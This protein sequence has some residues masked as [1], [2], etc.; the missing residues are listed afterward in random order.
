MAYIQ[1]L[2]SKSF[3][4]K[5]ERIKSEVFSF[6]REHEE[7]ISKG[8]SIGRIWQTLVKEEDSG[9]LYDYTKHDR[10]FI[11]MIFKQQL[12]KEQY[13]LAM[14]DLNSIWHSAYK[15]FISDAL[16]AIRQLMV[17][18]N[19]SS[20]QAIVFL[21]NFPLNSWKQEIRRLNTVKK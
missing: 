14:E 4:M 19:Y 6:F 3:R 15:K 9:G 7:Q 21:N 11:E 13:A 1:Q 10:E 5:G 18:H 17:K 16:G 12:D 2:A 8:Q 20:E